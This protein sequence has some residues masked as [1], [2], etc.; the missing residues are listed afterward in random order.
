MLSP[1]RVQYSTAM[2]IVYNTVMSTV[3]KLQSAVMTG[4][5]YTVHRRVEC[6]V[7]SDKCSHAQQ[8]LQ[9][10]EMTATNIHSTLRST[11]RSTV[12]ST[13]SSTVYSDECSNEPHSDDNCDNNC[14]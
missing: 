13:V 10:E 2:S 7:I 5:D 14:D 11:V 9:G 4:G 8:R 12:S 1:G 3:S 6:A